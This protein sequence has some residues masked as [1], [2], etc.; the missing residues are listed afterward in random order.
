MEVISHGNRASMRMRGLM[1]NARFICKI[2]LSMEIAKRRAA[3]LS[4]NDQQAGA[5]KIT[6][7]YAFSAAATTHQI[8]QALPQIMQPP[9]S[10][11]VYSSR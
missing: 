11:P 2:V 3:L 4:G 6:S 10:G 8:G 1:K 5:Y 7:D 9:A